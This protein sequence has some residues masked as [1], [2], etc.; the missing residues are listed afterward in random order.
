M[1]IDPNSEKLRNRAHPD[2]QAKSTAVGSIKAEVIAF[3]HNNM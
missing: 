2:E 1:E 3:S